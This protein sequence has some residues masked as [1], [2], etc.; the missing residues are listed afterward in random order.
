MLAVE[1]L[2]DVVAFVFEVAAQERAEVALV[3]DDED[4]GHGARRSL[5]RCCHGV[6]AEL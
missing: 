5:P 2:E 1:G 3:F 6:V 4:G